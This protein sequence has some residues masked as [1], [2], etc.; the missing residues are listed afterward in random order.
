MRRRLTLYLMAFAT[1]TLWGASFPLTK[2]ALAW[3]GPTTIAF[4]RW[5]I[6]AVALFAWLAHS[7][8]LGSA[9]MLMR[10]QGGKLFWVALSG[11]TLFY[12]LENLALQF[13]TATNAGVLA[14]F[15]SVFMVLIGTIWLRERLNAIEWGAML[16]AF[17]GAILVSQSAGHLTIA[18]T[19]L[20]GD[21]LMVVATF[22]AAVY[23]IG[24]KGLVT[25]YAPEVV[26]ADAAI[27]GA[28]LLLP[29]AIGE[30]GGL[31][32]LSTLLHLS[33]AAWMALLLLGLGAGAFANIW[34]LRILG[35][36]TAARAGMVLFLIPVI[37]TAVAVVALGEPLTPLVAI[38]AAL[39]LG[40]VA[41]VERD[42]ARAVN[43]VVKQSPRT[44]PHDQA[45]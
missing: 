45:S 26:L 28:L 12:F 20:Q 39:V 25:A 37:S 44:G 9:V 22:F 36:T 38:G 27:V 43:R 14:N 10:R 42:R 16:V 4:L 2:A 35:A 32:G 41:L 34:W 11:I 6:S 8:Q 15:T 7:R 23:S 5:M 3:A 33:P 19:G 17:A 21:L 1:V 13:T 18:N 29:L 30:V 40:G 31:A 24:G